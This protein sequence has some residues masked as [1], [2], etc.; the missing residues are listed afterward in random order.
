MSFR[1]I[2]FAVTAMAGLAVSSAM[3]Q[4]TTTSVTRE[5]SFPPIGLG[6]T[7]AAEVIVANQATNATNGTAASCTGTVSF[8]NGS[9]AAISGASSPFT[10]TAGAISS[11]HI[12]GTTAGASGASRVYIIPA[13]QQT[14]STGGTRAPCSLVMTLEIYDATTGATH[15]VITTQSAPAAILR[16]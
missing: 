13:V 7:E 14:I 8:T 12:T 5:Y 10:L 1:S 16:F 4:T 2:V 11:V 15:A 9:G 3:A 6:G